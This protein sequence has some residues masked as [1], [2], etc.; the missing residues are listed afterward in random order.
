[1]RLIAYDRPGYGDSTRYQGRSIAATAEDVRAIADHLGIERFAV[2]GRSGG[3]PHA[4]AVAAK[5]PERVTGAVVLASVAPT[6]LDGV[7]TRKQMTESNAETYAMVEDESR[8]L[9]N[10]A[11]TA[12]RTAED[13]EHFIDDWLSEGLSSPDHRVVENVVIRRQLKASYAEALRDGNVFGWTDDLLA[14]GRYWGFDPAEVNVPTFLWHGADDKFSPVDN[15]YWLAHKLARSEA[16]V[17]PKAGHFGAV[18][19]LTRALS[20]LVARHREAVGEEH[21]Q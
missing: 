5:L 8:L 10:L 2:A 19:V 13:P 20:W 6:R 3:G 7:D 17:D 11:P 4:L 14:L 21:D 18:E 1:V 12:A 15:T 9:A 16:Q